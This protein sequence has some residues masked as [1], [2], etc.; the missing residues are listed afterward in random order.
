MKKFIL[1]SLFVVSCM[2]LL[3]GHNENAQAN[4][5]LGKWVDV[6][7]GGSV[8]SYQLCVR[9]WRNKCVIGDKKVQL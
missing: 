6:Y 2:A 7:E 4:R 1:R 5:Y 8:P 9:A 3:L